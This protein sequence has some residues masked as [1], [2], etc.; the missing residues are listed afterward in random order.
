MGDMFSPFA[1]NGLKKVEGGEKNAERVV[2]EVIQEGLEDAN[3]QNVVL[4]G[5]D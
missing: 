2:G 5:A 4:G 3:L 1:M